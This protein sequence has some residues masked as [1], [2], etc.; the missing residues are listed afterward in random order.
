[1]VGTFAPAATAT[2][3]WLAPPKPQVPKAALVL[4]YS[5]G[6]N[7]KTYWFGGSESLSQLAALFSAVLS[8]DTV[9]FRKY[10]LPWR[11]SFAGL[12]PS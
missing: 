11:F 10:A 12:A 8:F 7:L 3:G 1:M 4:A 6:V 2:E 5:R 9:S